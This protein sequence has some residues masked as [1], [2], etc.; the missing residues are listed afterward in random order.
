MK[1]LSLTLLFVL[2]TCN[3][4]A[5]PSLSSLLQELEERNE[6]LVDNQMVGEELFRRS[7]PD[8]NEILRGI[9]D[10]DNEQNNDDDESNLEDREE[11]DELEL[12]LRGKETKFWCKA[13]KVNPNADRCPRIAKICKV[14]YNIEYPP[15][16]PKNG[17]AR[18]GRARSGKR[19]GGRR[20]GSARRHRGRKGRRW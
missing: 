14:D 8:E 7:D 3:V 6:G 16:K 20:G 2:C 1:L 13:C 19:R 15:P 11:D 12:M 4:L 18:S 5:N 10:D 9:D 17:R